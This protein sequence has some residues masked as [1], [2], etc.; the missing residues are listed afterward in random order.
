MKVIL[1]TKSL[2]KLA[3]VKDLL[4]ARGFTI[5]TKEVHS[6]IT[7]QPLS[8][9]TTIKG[10][11]N[12]ALAAAKIKAEFDL[13]I[14]M[15]GGLEKKNNK[16]YLVCAVAVI[17]SKRRVYTGVSSIF[18]VPVVVLLEVLKGKKFGEVIREFKEKSTAK[19]KV[20]VGELISR[21]KTFTKAFSLAFKKW[22][23]ANG[24]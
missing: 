19:D 1:G 2:D 14:G 22:Q 18:E 21:R 5:A 11:L 16:Y 9:R 7:D 24:N 13:A 15:E 20:L 10:A 3:V 17:D 4:G 6:G 8:R 23:V 12:R